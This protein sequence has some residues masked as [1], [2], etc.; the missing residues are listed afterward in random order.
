[1]SIFIHAIVCVSIII[2]MNII[3]LVK[4]KKRGRKPKN[5]YLNQGLFLE[6]NDINKTN[7]TNELIITNNK[8][9]EDNIIQ[10]DDIHNNYKEIMDIKVEKKKR[11][12]KAIIR[13]IILNDDNN[14]EK[15]IKRR[16]RKSN[17][18]IINTEDNSINDSVT[19]LL[20]HLPLKMSDIVKI[21]NQTKSEDVNNEDNQLLQ[22]IKPS[23][24]KFADLNN[25][26]FDSCIKQHVNTCISCINC[27]TNE[28]KIN[29]LTHEINK[30]KDGLLECSISYNK[31]IHESC[32]KFY[33]KNGDIWPEK[34][35]IACWWCCH[36]FDHIP[37]GIP[38]FVNKNIFY[39]FGCYCS[40]NCMMSYNIDQN[41]YKTYERQ[42]YIYQLKNSIDPDNTLTI[43]PA[44]PRQ[45]LKLFGGPHDINKFRHDFFILN[46]EYRFFMP[47]MISIIGIIEE[48]SRDLTG[49]VK[50]QKNN[51]QM[52]R[53]KNP[54]PK[55]NNLN[56]MVSKI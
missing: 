31:K 22:E 10:V 11:G 37:L 26:I 36:L 39:L 6:T 24:T 12:R 14:D 47:P 19:Y 15:K 44:G 32:V 20:A 53:R 7:Y 52:V 56:L 9:L 13:P 16:G 3:Y 51:S 8:I 28:N 42:T 23:I 46:R 25:D 38:E 4:K 43:H 50:L 18:K 34:T 30:L 27:K 55:H 2:I 45:S 41:D 29:D 1:M 48:D 40:F 35:D 17:T 33:G 5:Y 49:N 21:T 54:L